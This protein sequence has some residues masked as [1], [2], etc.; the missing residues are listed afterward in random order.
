M[1]GEDLSAA[2][3]RLFA[4]LEASGL[5]LVLAESCTGGLAAEAFTELPGSSRLLWGSIVAYTVEAKIRLLG[6]DPGIVETHG[7]VSR[8]TALAM[9]R[10]ALAAS[11]QAG[12]ALAAAVTGFAGPGTE[13]GEKGP[14]RVCCA[15][16]GPG[17]QAWSEEFFFQGSRRHVREEAATAL[18]EGAADRINKITPGARGPG[19]RY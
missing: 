2:A 3:G 15:W 14:G 4:S 19:T 10:G 9:A 11:G 5:R 17:D 13:G 1:G 8:Q 6:V 16:V 7:I 18:L 12:Q